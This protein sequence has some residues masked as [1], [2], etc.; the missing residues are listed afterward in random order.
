MQ[1]M[2]QRSLQA[3]WLSSHPSTMWKHLQRWDSFNS[4]F[5]KQSR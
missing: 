3:G 1:L 2:Q 4:H 5:P